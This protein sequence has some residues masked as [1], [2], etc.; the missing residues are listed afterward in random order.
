MNC[1]YEAEVVTL[2]LAMCFSCQVEVRLPQQ[3]KLLGRAAS[4]LL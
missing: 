2:E 1:S 4:V 3:H